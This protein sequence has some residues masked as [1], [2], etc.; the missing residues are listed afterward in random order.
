MSTSPPVHARS[1]GQK[2]APP[3]DYEQDSL[4]CE[5]EPAAAGPSAFFGVPLDPH[6]QYLLL[7]SFEEQRNASRAPTASYIKQSTACYASE[8]AGPCRNTCCGMPLALPSRRAGT[9]EAN[10]QRLSDGMIKTKFHSAAG[11]A[12]RVQGHAPEGKSPAVCPWTRRASTSE[13][14]LR[15]LSDGMIYNKSS[16]WHTATCSAFASVG[17]KSVT[18]SECS[19]TG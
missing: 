14:N 4:L 9:S 11:L 3:N 1:Q 18:T 7:P 16:L 6:C 13:A 8:A 12:Q 10:L 5:C 19:R 2:D 15:R 17:S